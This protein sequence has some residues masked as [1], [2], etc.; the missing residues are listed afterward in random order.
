MLKI[1]KTTIVLFSIFWVSQVFAASSIE[2]QWSTIDDETHTERSIVN[3]WQKQ[4]KW[5]AKIVK[6]NYRKGEGPK[7]ACKLCTG[8]EKDKPILGMTFLTDMEG[9]LPHLS[10]GQILDPHNGKRYRCVIDLSQ[11]GKQLTVRGYIGLPILGRSQ[12]WQRIQKG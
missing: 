6:I 7:D 12:T 1:F 10:G 8:S 9:Q 3:I 11:D 2:G 5:Y 4:N